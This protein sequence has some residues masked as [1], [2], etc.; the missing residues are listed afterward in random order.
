MYKRLSIFILI[1][2][3]AMISGCSTGAKTAPTTAPPA[4][5][6]LIKQAE[7]S[8]KWAVKQ[9][10]INLESRIPILLTLAPGDTVDGYFFLEKGTDIDF[11]I[12]GKSM[13]YQSISQT[14]GSSNITSDRF[15]FKATDAQ[16]I[17]YSLT[18][19]PVVN[20]D[21]KSITPVVFLE[22]IYPSTGEIF[23]PMGTK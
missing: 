1:L 16:G 19:K 3:L 13:I 15:S 21:S 17:A 5:L 10:R 7:I 9:V 8:G 14:A 20:K 22:L 4:N 11:E 6:D 2:A 18:F 12:S 23:N